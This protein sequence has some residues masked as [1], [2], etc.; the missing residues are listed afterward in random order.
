[1]RLLLLVKLFSL[2]IR[3][4]IAK[5]YWKLRAIDMPGSSGIPDSERSKMVDTLI[6][7]EKLRQFL[8]K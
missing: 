7:N 8:G 2:V 3:D 1:M 6:E 5:E 4:S